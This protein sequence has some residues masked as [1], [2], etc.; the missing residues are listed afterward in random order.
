MEWWHYLLL[1]I[2]QLIV[3][4]VG[5]FF[6]SYLKEEGRATS[7]R[8]RLDEVT[9]IVEE[10]KHKLGKEYF[11]FTSKWAKKFDILQRMNVPLQD[12]IKSI[13]EV[14]AS[15]NIQRAFK[16]F[17]AEPFQNSFLKIDEMRDELVSLAKNNRLLISDDLYEKIEALGSNIIAMEMSFG[18]W[19][20]EPKGE[21]VD[22]CKEC[23]DRIRPQAV[24]VRG[25][26]DEIYDLIQIDIDKM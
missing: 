8:K 12:M 20:M 10:I 24:A 1:M 19:H 14:T 23:D 3:A 6:G 17:K 4:G 26:L 7:I 21:H 15:I 16:E 5:A 25:R 18:L 2:V 22:V 11:I 13:G 9:N